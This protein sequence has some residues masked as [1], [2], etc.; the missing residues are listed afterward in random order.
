M[1]E[2][3]TDVPGALFDPGHSR[4]RRYMDLVVG[5]HGWWS[6][7]K[8]ELAMLVSGIPGALG[9]FLR[10]WLY[11]WLVERCGQD[12]TFGTHVILRHPHKIRIGDHVAIDDHAILDAKGTAN[13]GIT[14]GNGVFIGRH[15][16]LACKDG[17]IELEDGV[18]VSY[19]CLIFSA[20]VVRVGQKTLIAAQSYLVG[21]GH[22]YDALDRPVVEQPRP[23]KGIE[24]GP[25]CW[26]G[27]GAK[28]LDGVRIGQN[29]IVGANAVVTEAVPAYAVVGGIPARVIRD[30]RGSS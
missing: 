28:V 29:A 23:S 11:P 4:V 25:G 14:V 1:T 16:I 8:Y 12:V 22:E 15:S 6:L 13:R 7:I 5:R 27:A 24:I 20:S 9:L 18:N 10:S 19:H 17:E 3:L 30:R 21:G 26:I 2:R